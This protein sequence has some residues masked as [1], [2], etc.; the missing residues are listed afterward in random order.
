MGKVVILPQ[1]GTFNLG[2]GNQ[3]VVHLQGLQTTG[4]A[5]F[6]EH[7]QH[8][9][10]PG[11]GSNTGAWLRL[12]FRFWFRIR[13]R[14]WFGLRFRCRLGW[15]EQS[16]AACRPVGPEITDGCGLLGWFW[17]RFRLRF[18]FRLW[19]WCRRLLL[20]LQVVAEKAVVR[21]L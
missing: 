12:W 7:V 16:A 19:L 20:L 21:C 18:W 10:F 11:C 9:Q 8:V 2:Q 14:F 3:T 15:L 1:V 17:F 5:F 4:C 6:V 13:L